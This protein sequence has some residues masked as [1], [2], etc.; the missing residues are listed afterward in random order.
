MSKRMTGSER[1]I[2][3]NRLAGRLE[4]DV[5]DV[6]H[7]VLDLADEFLYAVG[8]TADW[9]PELREELSDVLTEL[10]RVRP[11]FSQPSTNVGPVRSPRAGPRRLPPA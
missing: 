11:R 6:R 9:P 3:L 8:E 5:A 4:H 10:A 1:Q 2:R 7:T